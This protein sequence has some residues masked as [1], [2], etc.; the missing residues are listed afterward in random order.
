MSEEKNVM[1]EVGNI[2]MGIGCLIMC[3]IV[4]VVGGVFIWLMI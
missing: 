3:L 4:L 1:K 2:F